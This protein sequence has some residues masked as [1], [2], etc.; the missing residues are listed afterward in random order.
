VIYICADDYG[1]CDCASAH[2]QQCI[3]EGGLS[4]V[5]VFPNFDKIDL[6]KIIDNKKFWNKLTDNSKEKNQVSR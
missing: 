5:S 1:L 3:D 6:H 2:I 4:K